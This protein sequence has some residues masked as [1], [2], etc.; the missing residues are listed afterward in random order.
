MIQKLYE[1]IEK[2]SGKGGISIMWGEKMLKGK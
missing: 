1:Q 2:K